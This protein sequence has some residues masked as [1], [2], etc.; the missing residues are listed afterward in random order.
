MTPAR[1]AW[2]WRFFCIAAL[3]LNLLMFA[4]NASAGHTGEMTASG[5]AAL[6]SG[7]AV[8]VNTRTIRRARAVQ[9]RKEALE[10]RPD[11]AAIARM[12]REIYGEA[13]KHDGAPGEFVPPA[14]VLFIGTRAPAGCRPPYAISH[15]EVRALRQQGFTTRQIAEQLGVTSQAVGKVIARHP[16]P[17]PPHIDTRP[18]REPDCHLCDE[19]DH[20]AQ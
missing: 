8:L 18:E 12:E 1:F 7:I 14:P 19:R 5:V 20:R 15:E 17:G 9:R 6:I 3:A 2:F 11:Y 16:R 13:F 10:R 4:G